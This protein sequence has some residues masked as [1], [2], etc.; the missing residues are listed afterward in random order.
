MEGAYGRREKE[1]EYRRWEEQGYGEVGRLGNKG[2]GG[3]REGDYGR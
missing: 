3:T 1:G 2:K